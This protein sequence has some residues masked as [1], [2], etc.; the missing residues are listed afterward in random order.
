M[1][2]KIHNPNKLPTIDFRK[3]QV[4]QGDLKFL[5]QKNYKK[6]KNV[7]KKRGFYVPLY[8]WLNNDKYWLIDGT[9]RHRV[10]TDE[11]MNDN[12]SYEVPYI[13]IEAE[14]EK[15][16]KSKILEISS[17]YG[18]ISYETLDKFI[19]EAE[20]PEF[21]IVDSIHF[22]ALYML[23]ED[24]IVDEAEDEKAER[25]ENKPSIIIKF[26]EQDNLEAALA[27]LTDMDISGKYDAEIKVRGEE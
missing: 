16:A 24:P 21:E 12:G 11:D 23:G 13:L 15:E 5:D 2:I 26:N 8:L 4:L 1:Q 7:L 19:F 20:L 27:D 17:Q 14:D 22:D 25:S 18:T 3:V 10:M 6:L 9:Q